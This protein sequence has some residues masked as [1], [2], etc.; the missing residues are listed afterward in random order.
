M[1]N[2]LTDVVLVLVGAAIACGIIIALD[3]LKQLI[4][5]NF[6]LGVYIT[7]QL[8]HNNINKWK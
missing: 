4:W 6:I 3:A 5:F 2:E 7:V 1:K 8:R